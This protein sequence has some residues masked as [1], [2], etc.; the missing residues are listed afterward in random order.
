MNEKQQVDQSLGWSSTPDVTSWRKGQQLMGIHLNC[1]W[2]N[3]EPNFFLKHCCIYSVAMNDAFMEFLTEAELQLL[4]R[5]Q[6]VSFDHLG[7][8]SSLFKRLA[9]RAPPGPIGDL[10]L[11]LHRFLQFFQIFAMGC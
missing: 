1:L 4:L 10:V 7:I 2:F 9:H 5:V 11:A 8:S 6:F 3:N